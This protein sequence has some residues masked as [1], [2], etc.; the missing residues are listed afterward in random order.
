MKILQFRMSVKPAAVLE[1]EIGKLARF[2]IFE[3]NNGI[4]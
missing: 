1:I 2:K 3:K 4:D